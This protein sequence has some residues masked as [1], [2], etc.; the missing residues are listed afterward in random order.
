MS[1]S[2]ENLIIAQEKIEPKKNTD[3][4]IPLLYYF[5]NNIT[6]QDPLYPLSNL[7]NKNNKTGWISNRFCTYPQEIIIEFHSFVNIKQINILINESKIPTIIEF[8]N[9]TYLPP[10]NKNKNSN[11]NEGELS[12]KRRKNKK[13][14]YQFKNI[15]FIKLS[16]NVETNYKAR[17]LRKIYI[18]ILTKKIKLIIHRNYS[19]T[20]N[21]FCQVGIVNLN[22][23]GYILNDED[24]NDFSYN[25]KKKLNY[26][27]LCLDEEIEGFNDS[28]FKQ[29]MDKQSEE[30]L[31]E[32]MEEME[33][34][35]ECEEYDECKM[36]K[37]EI[38]QLKK[39]TFKIYNLEM[40]KNDCVQRNDFD[41]AKKIKKDI[42]IFKKMLNDYLNKSYENENQKQNEENQESRN[43][44]SL[45]TNNI[46]TNISMNEEINLNNDKNM[47]NN[48]RIKKNLR[49]SRTQHDIF[50]INENNFDNVV[51]PTIQKRNNSNLNS[52]SNINNSNSFD[53]NI[54]ISNTNGQLDSLNFLNENEQ[55]EKQPLEDLLPDIKTKYEILIKVLGEET[56]QKVFSKYIYYK[57]E[58]FEVLNLK[59]KEIIIDSQK[60]TQETNKYIVSL[61]N[62]CF[63]FMDDRH[64]SIVSDSLELFTNILKAITERSNTNNTEYDFKITKR[65][66]NKVKSKLNHI[67]KKVR[68]TASNLYC[69][70]LEADFCEYNSLILELV[71][72]D[73]NEYFNKLGILNNNNYNFQ[74]ST[75]KGIKGIGITAN[76]KPDLSKQLIITKMNIFLEIFKKFE[77]NENKKIDVKKFPQ[78]IVGDFIIININHPKEEVRDITKEVLIKYIHIFGNQILGK[79]K[80]FID[81]KELSKLIQDKKELQQQLLLFKEE[82]R[83]K[84]LPKYRL[85]DININYYQKYLYRDRNKKRSQ[86]LAPIPEINNKNI[87]KNN[88]VKNNNSNIKNKN[89]KELIKSSS[90]PRYHISNKIKL[91]PI[92]NKSN[93]NANKYKISKNNND[94]LKN[95]TEI[96]EETKNEE[97]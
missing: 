45:T 44:N 17:E 78:N 70:M 40:Y 84:N 5:Q 26:A 34:K 7:L 75:S 48:N 85:E 58:G 1:T 77:K 23:F 27:D 16:S 31:K 94:N 8:I 24:N 51:L 37:R 21:T 79:L 55:I 3:K 13:I 20:L 88:N 35:K 93:K 4:I 53:N 97:N 41:N 60:T 39:I 61:I 95:I 92:T 10:E 83:K 9:C 69:Y 72:N 57:E 73:V 80:M 64:P 67:S 42:D 62:I 71:E 74:M 36:I 82:E 29:K 25:N 32:L 30:K 87:N 47:P 38:D 2:N 76:L 49:I 96:K 91:K 22:F 15:G 65:I 28:F 68:L 86:K 50:N 43:K 14:E 63:L 54:S 6:S 52:I 12:S 59:A 19:N 81:N 33:K 18:N 90:Q 66:L 46:N 89:N 56:I 11:A